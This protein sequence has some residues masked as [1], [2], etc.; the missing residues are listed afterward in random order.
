MKVYCNIKKKSYEVLED[1][2]QWER[3][4][5]YKFA[6]QHKDDKEFARSLSHYSGS[7]LPFDDC[8][9]SKKLKAYDIAVDF[10][11]GR[12]TS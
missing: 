9:I 1:A 7:D 11:V 6:E 12:P 4:L 10:L 5:F 2:E 8:T 3:E